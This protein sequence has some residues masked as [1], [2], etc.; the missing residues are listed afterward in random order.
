MFLQSVLWV[1]GRGCLL[2]AAT[3]GDFDVLDD[4]AVGQIE[5]IAERVARLEVDVVDDAALGI[6]EMPMINEV[7]AIPRWFAVEIHLPDDAM[8]DKGFEAIVDRRQRD[9]G[10][11][12]F[13]PHEN[14]V[15]GGVDLFLHEQAVYFA[16]LP[17]HPQ[18]ADFLR[19]LY[20][21]LFPCAL[22]HGT[23]NLG[24]VFF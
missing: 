20:G 22:G 19:D 5:N 11:P 21:G 24:L 23:R 3:E 7:R 9:V 8:L 1:I 17:R 16:A 12:V 4:G 10:K 18:S 13:G 14:I 2:E 6:V 15:G